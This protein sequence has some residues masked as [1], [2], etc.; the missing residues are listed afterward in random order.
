MN[1][2][3]VAGL[4]DGEGCIGFT[5]CRGQLIPRIDIANTNQDLLLMLQEK[6]GGCIRQNKRAKDN[7][8]IGY[9]WVVT[10]KLA[11]DFLDKVGKYLILKTNQMYCLFAYEAIRPG[12]GRDW[13]P[14]GIEAKELLKAQMHWLN[15]KG[16]HS[17]IEPIV[18]VLK[19]CK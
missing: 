4:V 16:V 5:Q 19:E 17:E 8:K 1:L 18:I 7:W 13:S 10:S 12:K 11:M 2:A 3:Y 14:D 15:K 6:F 9:H